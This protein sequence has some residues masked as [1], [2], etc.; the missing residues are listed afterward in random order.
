MNMST[1]SCT[2]KMKRFDVTEFYSHDIMT[3]ISVKSTYLFA[4]EVRLMKYELISR[5]NFQYARI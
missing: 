4:N 1:H 3:K 2:E 5:N